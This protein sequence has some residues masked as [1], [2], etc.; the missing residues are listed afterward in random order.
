[1][2]WRG[3][4]LCLSLNTSGKAKNAANNWLENH[5]DTFIRCWIDRIDSAA[6]TCNSRAEEM[7]H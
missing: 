4:W 1:M 7:P 2:L 6:D 5:M 3:Q